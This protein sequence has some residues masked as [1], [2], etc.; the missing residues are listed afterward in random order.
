[1]ECFVLC[2]ESIKS[3]CVRHLMHFPVDNEVFRIYIKYIQF[4]TLDHCIIA[5]GTVMNWAFTREDMERYSI[6]FFKK[7][8][9]SQSHLQY[10]ARF[11][12]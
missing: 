3:H 7:I 6:S 5:N 10:L 12:V 9:N 4:N 11:Y 2:K 8:Q 1:M